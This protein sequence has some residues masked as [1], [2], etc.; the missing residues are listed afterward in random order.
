M[1]VDI[2]IVI[3]NYNVKAFLQQCLY[4][5]K[6]ACKD[7]ESEVFVVDNNSVDD[8][9]EMLGQ[10]FPE[11]NLIANKKNMGFAFACNQAIK[12]AC[13]KYILLLNPD[14][15]IKEDSLT[16]CIGFMEEKPDAGALGVKM[17]NGKGKFLPESK[18]SLPTAK[19]AF[20]KMFGLST[21]FPKSKTFG[22][23]QLKYLDENQIHEVEVLSGA[24]MFIRKS[25]LDKIGLLDE[26]FFMYGED[27]DLSFRILKAGFKNYYFP[28]TTIIHY[29]GESTKKASFKYV[30]IFYNAMLIFAN[31]HYK[32]HK[33]FLF[34][35]LIRLA[36]YLRAF[37]ALMKRFLNAM[38]LPI[39]DFLLIYLGYYLIVPLWENYRFPGV[40][41]YPANLMVFYIPAYIFI[42]QS[43]IY[44]FTRYNFK[45]GIGKLIKAVAWGTVIILAIYSLLP[46]EYRYSRALIILGALLSILTTTLTRFTIKLVAQKGKKITLPSKKKAL[47]LGINENK[48][49]LDHRESLDRHFEVFKHLGYKKGDFETHEYMDKLEEYIKIYKIETLIFFIKDLS[50]GNIINTI[51]KIADKNLEFKIVLPQSSSIVGA[52]SVIDLEKVPHFSI[53]P[54]NKPINKVKKRLFDLGFSIIMLVISPLFL[55]KNKAKNYYQIIGKV[56]ANKI[57]WVSYTK[58]GKQAENS[59]P[60]LK[61]GIFSIV[62]TKNKTIEQL[63]E[64]NQSYAKDYRVVKDIIAIFKALKSSVNLLDHINK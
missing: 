44:Y 42:W 20:Y 6:K 56:F 13:G 9:I 28:K 60:L 43:M 46:E 48:L 27:I 50:A 35:S 23:Y 34:R 55:L 4:S 58:M 36:I 10:S 57:S 63:E 53:S 39:C 1:P 62:A 38:Y 47:I 7:I 30:R 17:I 18:R 2:S 32:G 5:V 37:I 51:L 11:V 41:A 52:K 31:K 33:Q 24:F 8:S 64:I 25:V 15:V 3:V 26:N 54:I 49:T 21:L 45:S 14:T 61:P 22:K 29:K 59:L 19:S 16:N 40:N 12:Q